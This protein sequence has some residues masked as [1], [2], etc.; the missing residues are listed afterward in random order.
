MVLVEFS[1]NIYSLIPELKGLDSDKCTDLIIL[2]KGFY[3]RLPCKQDINSTESLQQLVNNLKKENQEIINENRILENDKRILE[4]VNIKKQNELIDLQNLG[5]RQSDEKVR[6]IVEKK[7]TDIQSKH[8]LDI[9]RKEHE[10]NVLTEKYNDKN[11]DAYSKYNYQ[12][13]EK[14]EKLTIQSTEL[15][16]Q[17]DNLKETICKLENKVNETNNKLLIQ[18]NSSK[19]GK[20][21]ELNWEKRFLNEPLFKDVQITSKQSHSGDF[22]IVNNLK[23][24]ILLDSKHNSPGSGHKVP[25]KGEKGI[26]KMIRDMRE[27]KDVDLGI[28]FATYDI[29][30]CEKIDTHKVIPVKINDRTVNLLLIPNIRY[31]RE[32]D[33][34]TLRHFITCSDLYMYKNDN[35]TDYKYSIKK[36][37]TTLQSSINQRKNLICS[38]QKLLNEEEKLFDELN[39]LNIHEKDDKDNTDNKLNELF[40][41]FTASN[42][43]IICIEEFVKNIDQKSK[44]SLK[45]HFMDNLIIKSDDLALRNKYKDINNLSK[46]PVKDKNLWLLKNHKLKLN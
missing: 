17:N 13:I 12:Q 19:K 25:E 15:V 39:L 37:I 1:D 5:E 31:E 8:K 18:E 46:L 20:Q 14:I 4:Q 41:K 21:T 24:K 35:N 23:H 3:D 33:Y 29:Q 30:G 16:I 34:L 7:M 2:W 10:I 26:D 27:V 42:G 36:T 40:N 32:E 43:D 45:S 6:L 9:D 22:I 28:L 11:L 44:E 38:T